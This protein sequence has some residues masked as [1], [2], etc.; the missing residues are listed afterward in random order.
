MKP[1][2]SGS[3]V[4]VDDDQKRT[5]G[6][7]SA[8]VYPEGAG[9]PLLGGGGG[10]RAAQNTTTSTP[11]FAAPPPAHWDPEAAEAAE[12]AAQF[13]DAQVRKG[14]ATRVL[15]IVSL[16]LLLTAAM[17]ATFFYSRGARLFLASNAWTVPL[18]WVS[19]IA[20][21]STLACSERARRSHPWNLVALGVFTASFGYVVAATSAL[22][23]ADVVVVA[24]AVTA[25]V[26]VGA[27]VVA[28]RSKTDFTRLGGVLILSSWSFLVAVLVGSFVRSS[29]AVVALSAVGAV[30]FSLYL[31]FDLQMIMSGASVGGRGRVGRRAVTLDP[32]DYVF[33]ALT[34]YLDIINVFVN[35]LQLVQAASDSG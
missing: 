24:S 28:A 2:G 30:L 31:L 11:T 29:V 27:L 9:A 21:S 32:D 34:V 8:P 25:A 26:C 19:G 4:D 3:G 20:I 1:H 16:Q 15:S 7:P 23:S 10:G 18:S 12:Y 6:A 14:F 5:G 22:Y 35:V 33:G 13:A 17:T